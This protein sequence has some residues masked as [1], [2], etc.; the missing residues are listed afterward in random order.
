VGLKKH[1]FWRLVI[2]V[3]VLCEAVACVKWPGA[4]VSSTHGDKALFERATNAVEQERFDAADLMLQTLINTYPDSEYA[5]RAALLLRE[6]GASV[7]GS[8]N[9]AVELCAS[10][11]WEIRHHTSE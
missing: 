6:S 9:C 10:V 4:D 8:E 1:R 11:R 2:L 5:G 3:T 7:R